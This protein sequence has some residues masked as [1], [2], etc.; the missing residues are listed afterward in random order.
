MRCDVYCAR[1]VYQQDFA[2]SIVRSALPGFNRGA[3]LR[4]HDIRGFPS[5]LTGRLEAVRT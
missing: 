3:Y 1:Y 5:T 2:H 4:A